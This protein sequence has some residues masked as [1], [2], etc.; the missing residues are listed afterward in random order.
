MHYPLERGDVTVRELPPEDKETVILPLRKPIKGR[1]RIPWLWIC[2]A[3]MLAITFLLTWWVIR[4]EQV[5]E[6]VSL[7]S[8][9]LR[10]RFGRGNVDFEHALFKAFTVDLQAPTRAVMVLHYVAQDVSEG[11]VALR[12]NGE[13]LAA[14][15]PDEGEHALVLP[16]AKLKQGPN[17]LLFER[18][19]PDGT[20]QVSDLWVETLPVP[21]GTVVTLRRRAAELVTQAEQLAQRAELAS[22]NLFASWKLYRNAWI[23]LEGL[24]EKPELHRLVEV[25]L[26][27]LQARLDSQ[28]GR[29]LL[30]IE[31]SR[32]LGNLR[33][34]RELLETLP[35]YFPT[36][37]HRCHNL[38]LRKRLEYGI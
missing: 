7:S 24:D 32:Q 2:A 17:E 20:W 1:R 3:V 12:L 30:D 9:P 14:V 6:P 36:A 35:R 8:Q 11:E 38:G 29:L 10:L 28:C 16:A 25:Q 31:R 4:Q 26:A 33:R 27:E 21:E 5:A 37:E 13:R 18:S 34:T 22:E 23:T 19:A 15:S